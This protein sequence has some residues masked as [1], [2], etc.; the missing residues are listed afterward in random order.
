MESFELELTEDNIK[1]TILKNYLDN[2]KRLYTLARLIDSIENN[3]NICIDGDWGCGKTFF[4]NQ[5][6]YLINN[7]ETD[8]ELKLEKDLSDVFSNIETNNIIIYYDAWKNDHHPDAFESI[9]FN[10]LN[11]FPK[12]KDR[13][14]DFNNIKDILIG[15]GKN[16]INK[17]SYEIIDFDNI[18][19]YEELAE[20]IVTVEE[21]KERFRELLQKILGKKRMILIIDELD[22]CNPIYASKVLET[23]KH[24]YDFS[25]ITIIYLSLI[26]I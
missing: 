26:H 5:F 6:I 1:E 10:I 19:T 13:V 17:C 3:T 7:R 2:N 15:F 4:I 11:E 16:I 8:S 22:R 9:I 21:K 24:F 20:Q 23:I 14:E 25:N 12:Y 18:K